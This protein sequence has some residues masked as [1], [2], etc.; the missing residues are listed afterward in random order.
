M[1]KQVSKQEYDAFVGEHGQ[2]I[3]DAAGLSVVPTS[4]FNDVFKPLS[5]RDLTSEE[6]NY[7]DNIRGW[8]DKNAGV[9]QYASNL[10]S[11][12]KQI[13][14]EAQARGLKDFTIEDAVKLRDQ[15]YN[16]ASGDPSEKVGALTRG[17]LDRLTSE[18]TQK[19]VL[20]QID[21]AN[22]PKKY[23]DE[24]KKAE[25]LQTANRLLSQAYGSDTNDPDLSQFLSDRLAEGESA[26]ELSQFLQTTPQYLKKQS[27]TENAR[28]QQE[29][30]AARAALDAELLKSEEETFS[31]ATPSIISSY[32]KAGRLN[33]SG[34]Q[35][36]LAKARADLAKE[37]QGFLSNAAYNDSIRAQGYKR[38]D[39]VGANTQA[40]NQYLRQSEPAYQQK[41]NVQGA[42][43]FANF[44][45]P[46]ND[47]ARQYQVT[48]RNVARQY[49]LEDYGQQQNDYFQALSDQRRQQR[50]ALPYQ[51]AGSLLGAGIQGWASN[52]FKFGR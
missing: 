45:Q 14:A 49:E 10:G 8:S 13:L 6:V 21:R 7:W 51:L 31:R 50:S 32:M 27:E 52:G 47:L 15:T 29:S 16:I 48:D 33:S 37:R 44:Q 42:G 11:Q 34:L 3:A 38:E 39:F 4:S 24:G 30:A 17:A 9:K 46:Y 28:V 19:Q 5:G 18:Y 23:L 26:F 36:A 22:N 12:A 25:N 40:F 20:D 35:S 43:N 2:Q 41:F 1:G